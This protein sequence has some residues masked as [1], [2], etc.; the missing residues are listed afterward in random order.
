MSTINKSAGI[1]LPI[2]NIQSLRLVLAILESDYQ[3]SLPETDKQ[4]LNYLD[5]FFSFEYRIGIENQP[6]L[7]NIAIDHK[8]PLCKI[9]SIQKPLIFPIS[10][11]NRCE[12]K[13]RKYRENDYFLSG[14]L[15]KKREITILNWIINQSEPSIHK[16]FYKIQ[17]IRLINRFIGFYSRLTHN[18]C[19][20]TLNMKMNKDNSFVII[21]S[22]IGRYFPKKAWDDQYYDQMANSKFVLCPNGDFVWTYR[23]FEAILCGAIPIIEGEAEIYNGFHY[24]KL[25]DSLNNME[26][27]EEIARM[28]FEHARNFLTIDKGKLDHEIDL[29]LKN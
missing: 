1:D 28:N 12:S 7:K 26:Y 5:K 3:I 21:P 14:L 10:I 23:F 15:T 16:N 18:G 27:N 20:I 11:I 9:N 2:C 6:I 19:S 25:S 13:W 8:T 22:T 24:F 29:M 17:Q 4:V